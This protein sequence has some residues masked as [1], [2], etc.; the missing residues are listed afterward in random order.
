MA[1][2]DH[3]RKN[4][5][6]TEEKSTVPTTGLERVINFMNLILE[7]LEIRRHSWWAARQRLSGLEVT[8]PNKR[9]RNS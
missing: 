4:E 2:S 6:R 1:R 9:T 3:R 5:Q 8:P 7:D